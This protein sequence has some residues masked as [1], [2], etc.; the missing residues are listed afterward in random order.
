[1][2]SRWLRRRRSCRPRSMRSAVR[3]RNRRA[4]PMKPSVRRSKTNDRVSEL[5]KAASRIGDVVE[6]I[7]DHRRTDQSAGAE[8][9]DRGGA[10]RRGRSRLC[11]GGVRGQGAG[12]ANRQGDRRHRPADHGN[13]GCDRGLGHRHRGDQRHDR[14]AY[15]RSSRPLP[16]RW[17]SRA[18][19]RRKSPAMCSR[20]RWER[21]GSRRTSPKSSRVPARPDRPR[22]RCYRRRNRCRATAAA[23]SSKSA[24][25]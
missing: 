4:L 10:R 20:R 2:C 9:H 16:R 7:N 5:S 6:L 15:R 12:R 25:S 13:P 21:R 19:R 22:R 14:A 23:S 17:R 1:M 24:S 18:R 8:C 3:F 11:G